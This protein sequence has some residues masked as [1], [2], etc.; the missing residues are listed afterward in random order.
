MARQIG[1]L[2]KV[3]SPTGDVK[4][5]PTLIKALNDYADTIEP[6]AI[7]VADYMLADVMRRDWSMWKKVGKEMGRE[8]RQEIEYAPTGAVLKELQGEQVKLIKSLPL[9]AAERVH[10]LSMEALLSSTRAKQV[11]KDILATESVSKAKATLIARTEVS[12]VAA[13][14]KQARAQF[15]G[16]HGYIWRTSED[17]DVRKSHQGM[18]GV[19]VAWNSPPTLDNLKGHAGCLPNCRCFAE[20]LFPSS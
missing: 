9:S 7:A 11:A 2:V 16:S 5:S 14:L 13:N 20:P 17:S 1:L 15:A 12:R 8:L 10:E 18:N 19:Y 6:W 4:N 3:L